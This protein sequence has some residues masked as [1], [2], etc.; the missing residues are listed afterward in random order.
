[1]QQATV[2]PAYTYLL[3]EVN[4]IGKILVVDSALMTATVVVAVL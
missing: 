2:P 1:L 3:N 4:L